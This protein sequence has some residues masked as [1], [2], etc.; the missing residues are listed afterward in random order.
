M[1]VCTRVRVGRAI[2]AA[3]RPALLSVLVV[4][5]VAVAVILLETLMVPRRHALLDSSSSMLVVPV[6]VDDDDDDDDT[7]GVNGVGLEL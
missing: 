7:V 4:Q 3:F 1:L 6:V 2:V 5:H